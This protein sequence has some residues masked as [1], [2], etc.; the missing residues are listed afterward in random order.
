VERGM[1]PWIDVHLAAHVWRKVHSRVLGS[2]DDEP[3]RGSSTRGIDQE[4][5]QSYL[6]VR[7]VG[8]HV[9]ELAREAYIDRHGM[10]DQRIDSAIQRFG[11]L[12]TPH[13]LQL[14]KRGSSRK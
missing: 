2:S 10:I 8:A 1:I 7:R 9:A 3:F 11:A 5:F 4:F 12:S 6:A 13:L 14:D